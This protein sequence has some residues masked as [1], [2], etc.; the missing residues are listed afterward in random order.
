MILKKIDFMVQKPLDKKVTISIKN[1]LLNAITQLIVD[2]FPWAKKQI[3]QKNFFLNITPSI[4][5]SFTK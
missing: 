5:S 4:A 3:K 2:K 1:F